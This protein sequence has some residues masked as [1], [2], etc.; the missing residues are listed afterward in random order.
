MRKNVSPVMSPKREC[1]R[2]THR[3]IDSSL[4]KYIYNVH[5]K[6]LMIVGINFARKKKILC[7][8]PIPSWQQG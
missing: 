7:E 4:R 3:C 6:P 8:K 2:I 5:Y 1:E